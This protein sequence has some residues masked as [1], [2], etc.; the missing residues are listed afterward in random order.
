MNNKLNYYIYLS[1]IIAGVIGIILISGC[2][3]QKPEPL[4]QI[5][6]LEVNGPYET[7]KINNQLSYY[8]FNATFRNL[9]GYGSVEIWGSLIENETGKKIDS[10][11]RPN[12]FFNR[13]ETKTI[14]F[15]MLSGK[16]DINY[17]YHIYIAR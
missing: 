1:L 6:V 3:T 12:V 10:D 17:T 15:S 16:P 5:K 13:N 8:E 11:I 4:P 9:G 7:N 2:I 14:T